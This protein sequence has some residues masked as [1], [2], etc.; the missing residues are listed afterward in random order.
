[1]DVQAL[2]TELAEK[3]VQYHEAQARAITAK[4]A[5]EKEFAIWVT[6]HSDIV[7]ADDLAEEAEEKARYEFRLCRARLAELK[8]DGLPCDDKLHHTTKCEC[9]KCIQTRIE[10]EI[11]ALEI[12]TNCQRLLLQFID[13]QDGKWWVLHSNFSKDYGGDV[14]GPWQRTSVDAWNALASRRISSEF[15]LNT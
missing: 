2:K 11:E 8:G 7:V 13:Y 6:A 5:Y 9:F 12:I 4:N 1:M 15:A 10:P 14:Y 3:Q